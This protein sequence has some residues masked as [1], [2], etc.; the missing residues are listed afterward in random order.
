MRIDTYSILQV[1]ARRQ[2]G[3]ITTTMERWARGATTD[4]VCISDAARSALDG[5]YNHHRAYRVY[6]DVSSALTAGA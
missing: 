1:F 4:R 3:T 5:L 2:Y 6:L